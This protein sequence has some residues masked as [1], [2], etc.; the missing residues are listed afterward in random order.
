[1]KNL[2]QHIIF[3]IFIHIISSGYE[4]NAQAVN[5]EK[6]SL[7]ASSQ[8]SLLTSSPWDNEIYAS[9]GHSALRVYDPELGV[10]E[11]FNYG[12]FDFNTPNFA[13]RFATGKTDYI[14]A[15]THFNNYIDEYKSRNVDVYEQ[16]LNLK[17]NERQR[18]WE[19]LKDNIKPE[20]RTYRYNEVFNNCTTKLTE[21]IENNIDGEI[22]YPKDKNPKTF[23]KLISEHTDR[24]VWIEFGINIAFG[25]GTDKIASL[26]EKM[27]LPMY[28]MNTFAHSKIVRDNEKTENLVSHNKI[29]LISAEH[30]DIYRHKN[31]IFTSP[32]LVGLLLLLLSILISIYEYKSFKLRIIITAF[33]FILFFIYGLIGCLIVF[34]SFSS[35]PF[36]FPNWNIIWLNPLLLIVSFMSLTKSG[37]RYAYLFR[38][39]NSMILL[40]FYISIFFIPQEVY[41]FIPYILAILIRNLVPVIIRKWV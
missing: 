26:K 39:L 13:W 34:L 16:T 18:I 3:L 11:V 22:L 30:R 5:S 25:S 38:L 28:Q 20:N 40:I 35:H 8:I 21:I 6:D 1:M 27:F 9:F 19:F 14:V 17:L 10:D 31:I 41:E 29:L 36:T 15:K 23:R 2:L 32:I 24:F 12:I 4:I 33:D 37:I 7:S